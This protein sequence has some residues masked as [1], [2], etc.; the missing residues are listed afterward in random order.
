MKNI[1][2]VILAAGKSTRFIS[3]VMP[4]F[5]VLA[6]H[7]GR[8]QLR[9]VTWLCV[10]FTAMTSPLAQNSPNSGGQIDKFW[11]GP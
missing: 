11:C 8:Q 7:F 9:L 1:T 4:H 6:A 5:S 10:L 2:T 3:M